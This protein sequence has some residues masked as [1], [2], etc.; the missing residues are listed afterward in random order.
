MWSILFVNINSYKFRRKKDD[1][2]EHLHE[3][4]LGYASALMY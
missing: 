2:L 3:M 4:N 1:I